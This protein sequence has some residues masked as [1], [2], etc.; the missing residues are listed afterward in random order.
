MLFLD[1]SKAHKI[2]IFVISLKYVD[3]L[4]VVGWNIACLVYSLSGTFA[5]I[6]MY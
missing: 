6:A 3:L 4:L 1:A 2:L 5:L